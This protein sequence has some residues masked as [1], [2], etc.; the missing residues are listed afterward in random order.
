MPAACKKFLQ[1]Q[2]GYRT[3]LIYSHWKR[4]RDEESFVD[5]EP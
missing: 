3:K 4:N 1:L 2:L 5:I